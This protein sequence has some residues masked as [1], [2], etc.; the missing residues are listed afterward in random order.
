MLPTTPPGEA[1]GSHSPYSPEGLLSSHRASPKPVFN[2][3]LETE[4]NP[5]LQAL[6]RM[7][8][9]PLFEETAGKASSPHS[10]KVTPLYRL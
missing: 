8:T 2:L 7:C 10:G 4:L 6:K 5:V 3:H 1:L 9:M